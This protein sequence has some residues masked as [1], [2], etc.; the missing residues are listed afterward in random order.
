MEAGLG[1]F[2]T[3]SVDEAE[4]VSLFCLCATVVAETEVPGKTKLTVLQALF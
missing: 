3:P 1:W 4:K 2:V